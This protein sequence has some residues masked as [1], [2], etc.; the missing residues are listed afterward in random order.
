MFKTIM[1]F[2]EG[3]QSHAAEILGISRGTLR[4]KLKDYNIK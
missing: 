1:D 3:N 4:K 2:S